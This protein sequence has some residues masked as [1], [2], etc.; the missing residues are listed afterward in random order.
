MFQAVFTRRQPMQYRDLFEADVKRYAAFQAALLHRGV[1][2][3]S[4]PLACWFV[5]VSHQAED[6]EL[7]VAAIQAAMRTV[8]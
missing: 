4:S 7:T 8:A 1:H 6:V 2:C 5:S 3:T